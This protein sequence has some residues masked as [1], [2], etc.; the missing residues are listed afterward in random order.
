MPK[1]GKLTTWL[2]EYEVKWK[3]LCRLGRWEVFIGVDIRDAWIGGYWK[4]SLGE[5]FCGHR[6][7]NIHLILIPMTVLKFETKYEI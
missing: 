1:R 6:Y 2:D 4:W 5:P 7:L 3:Y